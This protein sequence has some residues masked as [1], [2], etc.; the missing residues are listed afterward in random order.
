MSRGKRITEAEFMYAKLAMTQGE[1]ASVVAKRLD[2]NASYIREII[3][4]Y[5]DYKSYLRAVSTRT[6][7]RK[8]EPVVTKIEAK[9]VAKVPLFGSHFIG[10]RILYKPENARE[11]KEYNAIA[12]LMPLQRMSLK[13]KAAQW[14][15][16]I[17]DIE[18]QEVTHGRN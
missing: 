5:P 8:T 15:A 6:P 2:R 16:I 1:K 10:K 11:G 4:K 14:I 9:K 13:R 7:V 18:S 3:K 17:D 12:R